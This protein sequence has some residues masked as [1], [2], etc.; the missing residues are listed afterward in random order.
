MKRLALAL[1]CL[2]LALL[3][4]CDVQSQTKVTRNVSNETIEK[5]LQSLDVKFTKTMP[6]EKDATA[7][8]DFKRGEQSCR[9]KNHGTDLWLE[10]VLDKKMK[11]EDINRWNADAKFSRLVLIEE[12]DKT[13][14]SLESQLD[15]L[16]GVTDAMIKQYIQR[17]D[18]ET[19]KFA[20][21]VK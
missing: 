6:K 12:K 1:P 18:E 10:C 2:A 8:Y 16:G 13:I 20:K 4:T 5:I 7:Y 21:F 3:V 14:V 19:K 15:C 17:F 11:L 9:L